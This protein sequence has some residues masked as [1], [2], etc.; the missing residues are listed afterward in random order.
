M[1]EAPS[2]PNLPAR[3]RASDS[4]L[5]EMAKE[6]EANFLAEMLKAAKFGEP[7]TAFGGGA[8][9]EQ[10]ASFLRLEVARELA[11]SGGLGLAEHVFES[12]KERQNDQRG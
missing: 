4:T 7:R 12:L 2:L 11:S 8:G 10:F 6:L 9:E 3:S 5:R 1:I